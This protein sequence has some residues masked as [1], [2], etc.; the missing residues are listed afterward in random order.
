LIGGARAERGS[1]LL[2]ALAATLLMLAL[3]SALVLIT[4]TEV[5]IGGRYARGAEVLA[6]AELLLDRALLDVRA[7]GE[8]DLILD[9]NVTSS[10]TDGA[11]A[12]V[13]IVGDVSLDIAAMTGHWRCGRP[14]CSEFELST[15]S[16]TR[17]WGSNNPRWQPFAWGP[18]EAVTVLPSGGTPVYV[19]A[20]VA[21]DPAETD[22][23]PLRDGATEDNPGRDMLLVRAEARG[24]SGLRRVLEAAV[25]RTRNPD[26]GQPDG[27][28]LLAW[29]EVR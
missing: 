7:A 24:P 15:V 11:A 5:R 25:R 10:L 8:W 29:R 21:D 26:T 9:G 16:A 14:S 17:P 6:G 28:E 20:W 12:G 13:R 19:V 1:A 3:G 27:L 2:S 22:G 23:D 4:A 18:L